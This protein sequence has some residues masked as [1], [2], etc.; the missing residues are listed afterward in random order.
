MRKPRVLFNDRETIEITNGTAKRSG[1]FLFQG[2]K[3]M[4]ETKTHRFLRSE[5]DGPTSREC[6]LFDLQPLKAAARTGKC[7]GGNENA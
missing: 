4:R 1:R 7:L 6:V 3:Q 5:G 2:G